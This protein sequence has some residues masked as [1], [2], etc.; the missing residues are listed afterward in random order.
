M[1]IT[2]YAIK[3]DNNLYIKTGEKEPVNFNRA[4]VFSDKIEAENFLQNYK[5]ENDILNEITMRLVR[6][7]II[8]SEI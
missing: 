4:S 7:D 3:T 6:L 2:L 1:K 8:E 5:E